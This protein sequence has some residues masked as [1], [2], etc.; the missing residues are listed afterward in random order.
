M[1]Q[2]LIATAAVLAITVSAWAAE[3]KPATKNGPEV[4][5]LKS[6]S[7]QLKFPHRK[8]QTDLKIECFTCHGSGG[9]KQSVWGNQGAHRVCMKCHQGKL[10]GPTECRSCH[11]FK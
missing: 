8:H 9:D 4:I 1:R 2:V 7:M 3:T 5:E 11:K 6:S 10:K